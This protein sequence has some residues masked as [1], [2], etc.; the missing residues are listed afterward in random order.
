MWQ[1][2]LEVQRICLS[3]L[4]HLMGTSVVGGQRIRESYEPVRFLGSTKN[5]VALKGNKGFAPPKML[6]E[7]KTS[8]FLSWN[9]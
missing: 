3:L 9:V 6:R 4:E 7:T 1:K 2:K 5:M 8:D